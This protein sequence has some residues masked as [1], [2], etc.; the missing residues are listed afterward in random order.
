MVSGRKR[1]PRVAK[2]A[3]LGKQP[4]P[5]FLGCRGTAGKSPWER[6]LNPIRGPD[7][8]WGEGGGVGGCKLVTGRR[9][10]QMNISD[11]VK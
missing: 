1:E 11:P 5:N 10:R 6:S 3:N 9:A 8:K 2:K 7:F 4:V